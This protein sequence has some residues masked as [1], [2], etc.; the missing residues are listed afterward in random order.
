MHYWTNKGLNTINMYGATIKTFRIN[1]CLCKVYFFS[2][3]SEMRPWQSVKQAVPVPPMAE[4]AFD[5]FS[6]NH[7]IETD[8]VKL[9]LELHGRSKT[10]DI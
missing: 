2:V 4:N 7:I 1:L 8:A 5:F 3:R 9:N 10:E 6:M